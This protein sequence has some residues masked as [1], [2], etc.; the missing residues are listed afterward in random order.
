MP[1]PLGEGGPAG[2]D[3][4]RACGCIPFKGCLASPLLISP[5]RGQLLPREKPYLV[6]ALHVALDDKAVLVVGAIGVNKG[7]LIVLV[8]EV[9]LAQ[10]LDLVVDSVQQRLVA[11]ADGRGDGIR[12]P[13]EGMPTV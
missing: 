13:R 1:S 4:G 12:L 6:G 9:F 5:L 2:P 8:E 10:G 11:L 7:R 3:E